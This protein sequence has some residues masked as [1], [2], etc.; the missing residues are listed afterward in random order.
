MAT[1]SKNIKQD[2]ERPD[3]DERLRGSGIAPVSAA[4]STGLAQGL[5]FR[6]QF[7]GVTNKV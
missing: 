3:R 4:S 7:A 6:P 1:S 2:N 5:V